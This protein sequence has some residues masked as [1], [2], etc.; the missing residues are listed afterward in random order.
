LPK[1]AVKKL[2]AN[3]GWVPFAGDQNYVAIDFDPGPKGKVG[4]IINA[5]RDD[6]IRHV[7]ADTFGEFLEFV[8][9]LFTGGKVELSSD[10]P[11][12]EPC[13]LHVKG[14]DDDLLTGLPELLASHKRSRRRKK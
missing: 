3:R 7:I 5:G 9:E 4:Q 13:W 14:T 8:A 12:E 1:G 6:E 10:D 11:P 2:Y